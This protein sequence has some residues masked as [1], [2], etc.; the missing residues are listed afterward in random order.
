MWTRRRIII[1]SVI[2]L[3]VIGLIAVAMRGGDDPSTPS[4]ADADTAAPSQTTGPAGGGTVVVVPGEEE[5]ETTPELAE[6][7]TP[8][9]PTR[10]PPARRPHPL[11][12]PKSAPVPDYST[13]KWPD[14]RVV[15]ARALKAATVIVAMDGR[16]GTRQVRR[17]RPFMTN[18][19]WQ[20]VLGKL[21]EDV[22]P[23]GAPDI[24]GQVNAINM[25]ND[26]SSGARVVQLQFDRLDRGTLSVGTLS[27]E[28]APTRPLITRMR[29]NV[30]SSATD[31]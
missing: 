7:S 13:V 9:R 4:A 27:F 29:I 1:A 22:P 17:I 5:T 18:A 20:D 28:F 21:R 10:K 11:I 30:F 6:P 19:V 25:A 23:K 24:L 14:E 16:E 31:S 3:V 12:I 26:P 2:T 8:A 15:A